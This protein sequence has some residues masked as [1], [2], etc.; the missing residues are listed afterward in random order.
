MEIKQGDT[1]ACNWVWTPGD[2]GPANLLTTTISSSVKVCRETYDLDVE[3]A[4]DGLSFTTTYAGSTA[5]WPVGIWNWD[6][7]FVFTTGTTRSETFRVKVAE[8][9][10]E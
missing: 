6:I 9:I 8:A 10:T 2:T 1:F 3:I 7:K 4:N 5:S